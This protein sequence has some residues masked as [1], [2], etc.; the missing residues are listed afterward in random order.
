MNQNHSD[1][2]D[3]PSGNRPV[4]NLDPVELLNQGMT[5]DTI[6][7]V[8]A[9]RLFQPPS[10][11][12]LAAMF[13]QF[14][15]IELI[16]A[17]GMG[18][19]YK[20]RQKELDRYVALKI[21]PR[22]ISSNP[23]FSELFA[24]EAKALA[25]LNHPHI[26]TIYDYGRTGDLF[27]IVMEYVDGVNLRQLIA[28]DRISPREALAIVPQICD[29]LQYA[30]DKG[31]VHRDIKPE[32]ILIDREGRVKVADFGLAKLLD[33]HS[34]TKGGAA[35]HGEGTI[36]SKDGKTM[37]TPA[38]MSPEQLSAPGSVDHRSDIYS[39]GVVFYQMLTGQLPEEPITPPS[40]RVSVDVRLDEVVLKAMDG[41]R[42]RRFHH[43]SE[44]KTALSAVKPDGKPAVH[45]SFLSSWL[46]KCGMVIIFL[47]V[48]AGAMP[49]YFTIMEDFLKHI[50]WL[51]PFL[52]LLVIGGFSLLGRKFAGSSRNSYL[53]YGML[54]FITL[55]FCFFFV[56]INGVEHKQGG[57]RTFRLI[58]PPGVDTKQKTLPATEQS[59]ADQVSSLPS[60]ESTA[61]KPGLVET[62]QAIPAGLDKE[63]VR[64]RAASEITM[65]LPDECKVVAVLVENQDREHVY[66]DI[67]PVWTASVEVV[68]PESGE[69]AF[70][71][72][73][74]DSDKEAHQYM[75]K[76]CS[77]Q[78]YP[79]VRQ[80][81]RMVIMFT[82]YG[83]Y[84][85]KATVTKMADSLGFTDKR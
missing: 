75:L 85:M 48:L 47:V 68:L 41:R 28:G 72:F 54:V 52:F 80:T 26:V 25:Q 34:D 77:G 38:Y 81:G 4:R 51:L 74:C 71:L 64:Y 17:G 58:D 62:L 42:E 35:I 8:A 46:F 24:R 13:R 82:E 43:A 18:A 21:L 40:R 79:F 6:A 5:E 59:V 56:N 32:N 9:G 12:E 10:A 31:V 60:I 7:G 78:A 30:H 39:L 66:G 73:M 76:H 84:G 2:T 1:Q 19:V 53:F 23:A 15:K 29:A 22:E 20:A 67:I 36:I 16:G 55:I 3:R 83:G 70:M 27:Y 11:E 63:E 65:A 49:P 14:D 69:L 57:D 45:S 50:N 44:M 61:A 33:A 37:G